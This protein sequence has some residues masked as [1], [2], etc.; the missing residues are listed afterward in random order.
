MQQKPL[1][2]FVQVMGRMINQSI[3]E[4]P[5]DFLSPKARVV[6]RTGLT[7]TYDFNL[8]FSCELCQFA[9]TNG[10]TDPPPPPLL[11]DSPGGE[12]SMFVAL[13][14]QLGLKLVKAKDIP[15]DVIVVDHAEKTPTA[16]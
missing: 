8:R 12:P 2:D 15:V 3:G 6:D 9:A 11:A 16:N 4:N 14:K 7:G 13:Q 10:N 5:N 1:G